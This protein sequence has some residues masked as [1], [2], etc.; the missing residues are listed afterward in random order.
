MEPKGMGSSVEGSRAL[1]EYAPWNAIFPEGELKPRVERPDHWW[2]W[3]GFSSLDWTRKVSIWD[4]QGQNIT[5]YMYPIYPVLSWFMCFLSH[6]SDP[7]PIM[8]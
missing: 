5:T 3:M 4:W 6:G 7:L 2:F 1:K 8:N